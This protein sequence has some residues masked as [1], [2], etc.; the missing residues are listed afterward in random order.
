MN[1]KKASRNLIADHDNVDTQKLEDDVDVNHMSILSISWRV[2]HEN[3]GGKHPG[4]NLDY[5]PSKAH[6]PSHNLDHYHH[7]HP[8]PLSECKVSTQGLTSQIFL[9]LA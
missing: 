1:E 4:F 7:H 3:R 6:P 8:N 2:P 5:S 9:F